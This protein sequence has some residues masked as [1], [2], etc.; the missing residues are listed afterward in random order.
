MTDAHQATFKWPAGPSKVVITGTFDSWSR[1]VDLTK[2]ASGFSTTL[3]LPWGE[4]TVYKFIVDGNWVASPH[5]PQESDNYGSYNNVYHS[6]PKPAPSAIYTAKSAAG[7]AAAKVEDVAK[8]AAAT[9][10]T[11]S[12]VSYVTSGLGA[13]IATVTG[14]DP[15]NPPQIP[16]EEPEAAKAVPASDAT[17][18]EPA[19]TVDTKSEPAPVETKA[20]KPLVDP[21]T[22][23]A[24]EPVVLKLAS[25]VAAALNVTDKKE[26]KEEPASESKDIP[27]TDAPEPY[28]QTNGVL[29]AE[30]DFP[31]KATD[32]A[33]TTTA[34]AVAETASPEASP[35]TSKVTPPT[36]PHKKGT[37]ESLASDS[38]SKRKKRNSLIVK[39]KDVFSSPEKK[40]HKKKQSVSS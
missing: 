15:I 9:T 33:T 7:T 6:P 20:E 3:S 5:E 18:A 24:D 27:I 30:V 35:R 11:S 17:K 19:P 22:P 4:K 34:T 40:A 38:P 1:S 8:D 16:V 23:I 25:D 39:L 29:P 14:V 28:K 21:L 36:S 26:T 32:A 2:T 13:A 12:F 10:G 37:V 31:P